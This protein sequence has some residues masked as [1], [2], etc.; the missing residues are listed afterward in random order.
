M[1]V[2]FNLQVWI[3]FA[4]IE[5]GKSTVDVASMWPFGVAAEAAAHPTSSLDVPVPLGPLLVPFRD[6]LVC[7]ATSA[8]KVS[9]CSATLR[10][11]LRGVSGCCGSTSAAKVPG[12]FLSHPP[13]PT[14][15]ETRPT[16]G[17]SNGSLRRCKRK[18]SWQI[19]PLAQ[20]C[21]MYFGNTLCIYLRIC[22]GQAI[23]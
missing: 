22:G 19:P 12:P 10:S 8:A 16:P 20:R 15:R 13:R 7:S 17:R 6:V 1:Y 21:V 11:L 5:S 18:H 3:E 4:M 2:T 14:C 9:G 23:G